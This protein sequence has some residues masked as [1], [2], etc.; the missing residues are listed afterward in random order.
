MLF[1]GAFFFFFFVHVRCF[2]GWW[3]GVETVDNGVF[4]TAVRCDSRAASTSP[5][6]TWPPLFPFLPYHDPP[7]PL[8]ALYPPRAYASLN[9]SPTN[10]RRLDRLTRGS[11]TSEFTALPRLLHP[12]GRP[13][14]RG[15][16]QH[17]LPR[18]Q[19]RPRRWRPR[20]RIPTLCGEG[21]QP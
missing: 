3:L 20:L 17:I 5:L 6:R 11:T 2:V 8:L 13:L 12:S 7:P 15:Q 14:L 1:G 16:Q 9:H 19:P 21:Q 10:N 4:C 18:P